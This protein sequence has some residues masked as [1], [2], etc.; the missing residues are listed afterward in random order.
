MEFGQGCADLW[1]VLFHARPRYTALKARFAVCDE[2][3]SIAF[4][5]VYMIMF[6][7]CADL[8]LFTHTTLMHEIYGKQKCS[9]FTKSKPFTSVF[10][11]IFTL[12]S[13][14]EG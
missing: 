12:K 14:D 13:K 7:N 1:G 3:L 4:D 10:V 6:M 11:F 8:Y 9:L 5:I 2:H